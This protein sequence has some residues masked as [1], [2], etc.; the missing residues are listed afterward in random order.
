MIGEGNGL[1]LPLVL[2]SSHR[3]C[4]RQ[5]KGVFQSLMPADFD[6]IA[7]LETDLVNAATKLHDEQNY[8]VQEIV[9]LIEENV[10]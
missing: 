8:S 4:V 7:Q 6:K 9:D 1:E 5:R 10:G 3:L 2:R